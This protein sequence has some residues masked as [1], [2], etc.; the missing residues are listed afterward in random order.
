MAQ[1]LR[2]LGCCSRRPG[3]TPSTYVT[4]HLQTTVCN[5]T[6]KGFNTWLVE[7]SGTIVVHIY[8]GKSFI[9]IK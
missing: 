8:V 4:T 5:S 9:L 7:A 2:A 6:S 3:F 1:Q